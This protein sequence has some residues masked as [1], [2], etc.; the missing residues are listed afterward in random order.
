MGRESGFIAARAALALKEVNFVLVPEAPFRLEGEG[1]LLP[2]LELLQYAC[3]LPVDAVL[4]QDMGLFL[5]ARACAKQT[6]AAF[7]KLSATVLDQAHIG[8]GSRVGERGGSE[9]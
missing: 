3:T 4:V 9:G 7:I 8:E 5:L 2:A 6:D 1:G